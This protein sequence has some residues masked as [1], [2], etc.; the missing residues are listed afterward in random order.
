MRAGLPMELERIVGKALAKSAHERYQHVEELLVDLR[1]LQ[2]QAGEP[3]AS[4]APG[5]KL[6]TSAAAQAIRGSRAAWYVAAA[7]AVAVI[8]LAGVWF[9]LGPADTAP[10][11]PLRVV[12]I[13]S[14]AGSERE[15]SFSPDGNQVAFSWNG[16]QQDNYDIYVTL[17]DGGGLARLTTSPGEDRTPAWSPDGNT[18][19]FFRESADGWEIYSVSPLG[20]YERKLSELNAQ[21]PWQGMGGMGGRGSLSWSPDGK[22]LVFTDRVAQDEPARISLL[23]IE[24]GEQRPLTSPPLDSEGDSWGVFSPD[25][26]SLAIARFKQLGV[27]DVFLVPMDGGAY[28]AYFRGSNTPRVGVDSRRQ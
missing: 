1:A 27:S 20:S 11:E 13:T 7:L 3:K 4:R 10:G 26:R 16:E 25:G 19:A 15:P 6:A 5:A 14:Y 24:T 8:A 21:N 2:K 18:I 12:P 22:L 9:R 17:V 23:S 28:A